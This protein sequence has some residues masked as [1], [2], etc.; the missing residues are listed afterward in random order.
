MIRRAT[1]LAWLILAVSVGVVVLLR[2]EGIAAQEPQ[3][4]PT[5]ALQAFWQISP[6]QIQALRIEETETGRVMEA[7]RQDQATWVL[8][9]P[10]Q[11]QADAVRLEQALLGLTL[12]APYGALKDPESLSAYGLEE[13]LYLIRL[14]GAEGNELVLH[15]GRVD[16]TG[17]MQY[18]MRPSDP[19]V[20][21]F[22]T[23]QFTGVLALLDPLPLEEGAT[24]PAGRL[25]PGGDE[26]VISALLRWTSV[27]EVAA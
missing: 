11:G 13:P 24:E 10:E 14:T 8:T 23:Y 27:L 22:Q 16:P 17:S 12:P 7:H 3:A 18:V 9:L 19:T 6:D 15:I 25:S 21:L 20:Y 26:Q 2:K 4:T 1:W 5:E